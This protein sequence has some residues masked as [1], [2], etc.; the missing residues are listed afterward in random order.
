MWA[1]A[2][3][4]FISLLSL[5]ASPNN[6]L[7][8][9]WGPRKEKE[10]EWWR[11]CHECPRKEEIEKDRPLWPN[12]L[13]TFF[14]K[15]K[16]KL[17]TNCLDRLIYRLI[18]WSRLIVCLFLFLFYFEEVNNPSWPIEALEKKNKR[19]ANSIFL[20]KMFANVSFFLLS[21][22]HLVIFL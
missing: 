18:I 14:S 11:P 3:L 16:W 21:R 20:K 9:W 8:D 22:P 15:I 7:R 19:N 1:H 6:P 2:W 17:K 4:H 10:G 13:L 5:W 12:R